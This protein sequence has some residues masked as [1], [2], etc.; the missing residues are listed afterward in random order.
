LAERRPSAPTTAKIVARKIETTEIEIVSQSQA[1]CTA[2]GREGRIRVAGREDGC[3][4][5]AEDRRQS[6]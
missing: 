1:G 6:R 5:G 3:R 2:H 4:H